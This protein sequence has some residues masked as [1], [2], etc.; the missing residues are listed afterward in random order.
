MSWNQPNQSSSGGGGG[1][2]L[3]EAD[4]DTI[5]ELNAIIAD[6]DVVPT[7][8]TITAG[9]GL[10]GGGDLSADRTVNVVANADGS[11][12]ANAND[13]QVGVINA[14]QHGTLAGGTTHAAAI[15]SGASGF[16]TGADKAKL[17][18]IE[19]LAT[20]TV[21]GAGLT[22]S[23][24]TVNVIANADASIVVNANDIQVGVLASDAQHGVRGGGTQ[25]SNA[26]AS[27]AAGFMTGADKAKLDGVEAGATATVAGAG[28]TSSGS[29]VNVI[30]NADGSIVANANDIQVGVINATQHG[31][32]AGGS[33]HANV[34]AAGAAGY[35]TGADKTKLDA[36]EASAINA[37][38]GAGMTKSGSTL[39]V[40]A[41]A[42]ASI[43]VNADDIQV[44]VISDAQHGNRGAASLH[45]LAGDTSGT[46]GANVNDKASSAFAF[47]G[48]ISPSSLS[49]STNN[50]NPTGLSGATSIRQDL[51]AD[52][53]ITGL[54]GGTAGRYLVLCNINTGFTLTL[55]H[56]SGSSTAANTF[57]CPGGVDKILQPRDRCILLYDNVVSVWRIIATTIVFGTTAGTVCAGNDGRLGANLF[58]LGADG[59]VT[60]TAALTDLGI[61][62]TTLVV[63][64]SGVA[65]IAS[66][67]FAY[68]RAQTSVTI[69]AACTLDASGLGGAGVAGGAGGA[70]NGATASV[71][72]GTTAN[73]Q[74]NIAATTAGT[75]GTGGAAGAP[76]T[77]GGAGNL[78]N[79][80]YQAGTGGGGGGGGTGSGAGSAGRVGG[81]ATTTARSSTTSHRWPRITIF[82]E[83]LLVNNTASF[84]NAAATTG[85]TIGSGGCGGG[86]GGSGGGVT[87]GAGGNGG[88]GGAGGGGWFISSMAIIGPGTIRANGVAGTV[89]A[90]G[91]NATVNDGGG[92]G[93][94]GGAGGAGGG[95]FLR[96]RSY[97][98]SIALEASGAIGGNGGT[99]GNGAGTGANGGNGNT[100][101]TGADGLITQTPV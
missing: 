87:S 69:N 47:S 75:A 57:S 88:A 85:L 93:G 68:I 55:S 62:A 60:L 72:T 42:D 5:A 86:G 49:G 15:A 80:T 58:G 74:T 11:I 22:N 71:G 1:G 14:T 98:G 52:S 51:S 34:I 21:A 18:G 78:G 37:L 2:D 64:A 63:N 12:V 50:Y 53:T 99:K 67:G 84:N 32:L 16:L 7:S 10:T 29:T 36:I 92:G 97:S 25:H 31:N 91:T 45:T 27:G 28:L 40:I 73:N 41:N 35:M 20:A 89:G 82:P 26:V 79:A 30:A 3:S 90:N 19:A 76:G 38:A 6:G 4:I 44:G 9:A 56:N 94:G 77:A 65:P 24:S 39:N 13:I 8:R 70:G 101:G 96:A 23:G 81:V 66:T 46:L 17:D 95:L 33:T 48:I 43:V 61:Y 100:G 59:A 83:S 54:A